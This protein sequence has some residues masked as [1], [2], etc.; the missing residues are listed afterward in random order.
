MDTAHQIVYLTGETAIEAD[1]PDAHGYLP[2]HR[3]LIE[4]VQ[5]Q[6]NQPGQWFL[7]RSINPWALTYLANPSEN[8]N[9]DIVIIPQLAQLLVATGLQYVTFEGLT[10]EHDNFT[11]PATGCDG[12]ADII[13]AVSFE[14]SQNITIDSIT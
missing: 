14:N 11:M 4:N 9:N 1:H 12:S 8:P 5:Y 3:Y 6:L 7:D 2:N 13:P 10:F